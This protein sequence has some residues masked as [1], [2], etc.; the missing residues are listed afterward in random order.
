MDFIKVQSVN[1]GLNA[2]LLNTHKDYPSDFF[3]RKNGFDEH[4]GLII[5]STTLE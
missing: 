5:L 3:Y 1:E 2:I 4:Q